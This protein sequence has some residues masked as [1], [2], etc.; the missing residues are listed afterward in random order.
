MTATRPQEHLH[1]SKSFLSP[2]IL[3]KELKYFLATVKDQ[4]KR[5][6]I[7][8][9]PLLSD[10]APS[11]TF[12]LTV[13]VFFHVAMG[14]HLI[15]AER[16]SNRVD[17]AYLFYLPL[18]MIFVSS[19]KLHYRCADLFLRPNQDFVVWGP[20]LREDLERLRAYP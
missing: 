17:I 7:A 14:V 18:A 2:V 19:G 5:W 4:L 8:E 12:V 9:Y 1:G 11:A 6:S 13:E 10:Y 20:D 16:A 15:A 3:L